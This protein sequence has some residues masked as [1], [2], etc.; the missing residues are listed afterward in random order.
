MATYIVNASFR[1]ILYAES[2]LRVCTPKVFSGKI[3][4]YEDEGLVNRW[5][6]NEPS[7]SA[8]RCKQ[9]FVQAWRDRGFGES[10]AKRLISYSRTKEFSISGSKLFQRS[11]LGI[12]LRK[13]GCILGSSGGSLLFESLSKSA[14]SGLITFRH[15]Y[16]SSSRFTFSAMPNYSQLPPFQALK[17]LP[18]HE[19][20][21]SRG[22]GKGHVAFTS[23]TPQ[24]TVGSDLDYRNRTVASGNRQDNVTVKYRSCWDKFTF[25]NC[26]TS[27]IEE[28]KTMFTTFMLSAMFTWFIAEPRFIPSLSMYPTFEI[29]DRIIAEKVS[30][31]LRK[32]QINDI[33]LFKAPPALQEK[34]YNSGAVFIKRVVAQGGDTVQVRNGELI[35]NGIVRV[36]DFIAEPLAYD[37]SLTYVPKG[38]VFVMGDNRNFSNDSHIW[39]PLPVRNILGRSVLR[40]WPPDRAGS[41]MWKDT[42]GPSVQ[43][44]QGL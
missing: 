5:Q 20:F 29:G 4:A 1:P 10:Q 22:F 43:L 34:G 32:P 27:R 7:C 31:Y 12:P 44:L 24:E 19:F 11:H 17:W 28:S 9:E 26:T 13:E 25:R 37:M 39:G 42:S 15:N 16:A 36:E 14:S 23:V 18:C 35:V 30:Y 33:V 40:Y 41:T 38:C 6:G 3:K 21:S 8:A 2:V